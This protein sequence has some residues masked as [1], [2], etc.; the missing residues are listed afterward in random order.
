MMQEVMMKQN[1][2]LVQIVLIGRKNREII[3]LVMFVKILEEN[4]IKLGNIYP[5]QSIKVNIQKLLVVGMVPTKVVLLVFLA[6]TATSL[7]V[8]TPLATAVTGGVLRSTI[9]AMLGT[10]SW[11]TTVALQTATTTVREVACLLGA[12]GIERVIIY[13]L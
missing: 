9:Q 6:V 13:K 8:T 4:L 11:A 3:F 10:A 12:S 5:K 7:D 2:Y 1:G